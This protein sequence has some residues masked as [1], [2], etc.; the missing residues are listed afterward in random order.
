MISNKSSED[1]TGWDFLLE[2]PQSLTG[3]VPPDLQGI[4]RPVRAQVKSKERGKAVA[5]LKLSNAQRFAAAPEPCFVI[6][7]SANEGG[8]PV[9]IFAMH[10]WRDEIARTLKRLREADYSDKPI[11]QQ[12]FSITFKE[13]DEHTN[14]LLI[15]MKK[16]VND[17]GPS[18]ADKKRE[19]NEQIGYE[20]GRFVGS[21]TLL[22]KDMDDFIDHSIG[23]S[24]TVDLT[25]ARLV[26]RRFGI[27]AKTPILD[28]KPSQ[29]SIQS[30]PKPCAIEITD[31]DDQIHR[32][33]GDL[34][35]PGIPGLPIDLSKIRVVAGPLE[36]IVKG[37]GH[38]TVNYHFASADLHELSHLYRCVSLLSAL[39]RGTIQ[40]TI[41]FDGNR[42]SGVNVEG[43]SVSD[44]H[45]FGEAACFL[46]TLVR[47]ANQAGDIK[48]NLSLDQILE[49]WESVREFNDLV[50]GD[51]ISF[52][53]DANNKSVAETKVARLVLD[54]TLALGGWHFTVVVAY[55]LK[56]DELR[57]QVRKL[58]FERPAITLAIVDQRDH[59]A[60][61]EDIRQ[62]ITR[63]AERHGDGVVTFGKNADGAGYAVFVSDKKLK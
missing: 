26:D 6:L 36:V 54:A 16:I 12:S 39:G 24:A 49:G 30:H 11:N 8:H 1:R 9:R 3:G 20:H 17:A 35:V 55:R 62:E 53:L 45:L 38:A 43:I 2:F 42:L 50:I 29:V 33:E 56:S 13:S 31:A 23:L 41:H 51:S 58:A 14:D 60:H 47:V 27:E 15:W 57:Q 28:A 44:P 21:I 19:L 61:A 34:F 40:I 32:F 25:N 18:Y 52:D 7:L 37:S 4:E 46:K 59:G 63:Y 22:Y 5:T 48:P 10:F